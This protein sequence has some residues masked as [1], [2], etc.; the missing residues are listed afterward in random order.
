[1]KVTNIK[2]R[3]KDGSLLEAIIDTEDL[4]RVLENGTWFAEWHKDFNSYL[5]QTISSSKDSHKH[6]EKQTLQSFLLGLSPYAPIRHINGNTLDNRKDNL[7]IYNQNVVN[8]YK[9]M[10]ESTIAVLLRD[11][12]GREIAT[13]LIDKEDLDKVINSGHSWVQYILNHKPYAVSNTE[14]GRV[15]MDRFIMNT[16]EAM[17]V[18]HI[19]L[20]PLD[21]RK[22]N[23]KNKNKEILNSEV[24]EL[25]N[26]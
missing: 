5:V 18:H 24:E 3:K 4:Q 17:L 26:N 25:I 21:N 10:D 13:T 1:V 2:I 15:Y 14:K 12:Y 8:D 20:N 7:E 11:K 16:G 6:G 23:L 22:S 19:N 9:S